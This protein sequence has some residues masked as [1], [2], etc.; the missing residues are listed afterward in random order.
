M[1]LVNNMYLF[2]SQ[3]KNLHKYIQ[4]GM[5]LFLIGFLIPQESRSQSNKSESNKSQ[6]NIVL[7]LVDDM[8]YSDIGAFGSEIET[9]NIDALSAQG[10]SMTHFYSAA[11]CETTRAS[12][13]SGLHHQQA[14]SVFGGGY[15]N[16]LAHNENNVTIPELLRDGGYET[17]MSGKWHLGNWLEL[18]GTPVDRGFDHYFGHLSGAINYFTG[19]GWATGEPDIWM[20]K[21]PYDIP[22]NFYSTDAFTD[23]AIDQMDQSV[24]NAN[25][26]FLYL[27]YNAPHFPLQVPQENIDKYLEKGTYKKGWDRIREQRYERMKN[28]GII[29]HEWV[30]TERD[31]LVPVWVSLKPGQ[32]E[33]EELLMATYA[34]MM[35]R[36]DQQIGRV[37]QR[38]SQLGIDNNTIIMFMSDNGANPFDF[39]RTPGKDPGPAESERWYNVE[40]ANVGNTPFRKYKQW[41]HEGGISTP[42]IIRWPEVIQPG[43]WSESTGHVLDIMPTLLDISGISYPDRFAGNDILPMEGESLYPVLKGDMDWSRSPVIYEFSGNR[44]VKEDEWKLVAQVGDSWELYNLRS[45]RTETKNLIDQYP[46]RV[47][48]MAKMYEDWAMRVGAMPNKEAMEMPLNTRAHFTFETN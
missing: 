2:D 23:Y 32:Q 42:L 5:Y 34:G 22:E 10:L 37:L 15:R 44:F 4:I 33:E 6:P 46:D 47:K 45:D 39:N 26:F 28:L 21:E 38:L 7:I 19:E 14:D 12:L 17:I 43:S 16:M 27:S 13:M 1:E 48:R 18:E 41:Q 3:S 31:T 9:P 24:A 36:L 11:K 8:G 35:D 29:D 25:P 40:W 20:G 30:L